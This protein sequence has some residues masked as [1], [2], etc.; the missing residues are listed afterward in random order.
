MMENQ[1]N[2]YSLYVSFMQNSTTAIL[3]SRCK[4]ADGKKIC[5]LQ[6]F[7]SSPE[8]QIVRHPLYIHSL[9]SPIWKSTFVW[10]PYSVIKV[11]L[12]LSLFLKAK[13]SVF[14]LKGRG[15]R[16]GGFGAGVLGGQH[17][18]LRWLAFETDVHMIRN[19]VCPK[20]Y[21]AVSIGFEKFSGSL[22]NPV[23]PDWL[24][25]FYQFQQ[26]NVCTPTQAN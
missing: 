2:V 19:S 10:S 5:R 14:F 26:I 25:N 23:E 24:K 7:D 9:Q 20:H 22:L 4:R 1:T 12:V 15:R 6:T 16:G 17:Q 8:M 21:Q 18:P 3:S 13:F 11:T